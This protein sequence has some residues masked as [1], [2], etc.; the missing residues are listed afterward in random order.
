MAEKKESTKIKKN[1]RPT[2]YTPEL[3]AEICEVIA[4]NKGGL[5]QL[6]AE[7]PHWPVPSNIFIWLR[8]YKEFRESY[9]TA[10]SEQVEVSIDYM[11]EMMTEPHH[12]TDENGNKR[13]DVG[14][15]RVKVDAIKWKAGKLQAKKYGV[16]QSDEALIHHNQALLDELLKL[17]AELD[18]K[19]KKDY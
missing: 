9:A 5:S 17:R 7:R 2:L 11:Q 12:Y 19:N 4:S 8:R 6:C 18:D 10:K 16:N 13:V 14:M 1:G 3:A 15:M